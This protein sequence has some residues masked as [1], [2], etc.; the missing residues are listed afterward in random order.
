MNSAEALPLSVT[1]PFAVTRNATSATVATALGSGLFILG[2]FFGR[3][4]IV[5]VIAG[6][7]PVGA[8]LGDGLDDPL[9]DGDGDG[10]GVGLGVGDGD[11]DPLGEADGE[12]DGELDGDGV[13][14]GSVTVHEKP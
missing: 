1:S 5:S 13:T 9:E 6:P 12:L 2:A 3:P 7:V 10:D 4:A 8:G 11:P 14:T